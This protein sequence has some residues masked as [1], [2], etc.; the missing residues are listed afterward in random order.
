MQTQLTLVRRKWIA[1]LRREFRLDP[2][3]TA[4]EIV[5]ARGLPPGESTFERMR[6]SELRSRL[7]AAGLRALCLGSVPTRRGTPATTISDDISQIIAAES[8][9]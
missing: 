7:R 5:M 3:Q 8:A 2:P 9:E 1:D 4:E 6:G